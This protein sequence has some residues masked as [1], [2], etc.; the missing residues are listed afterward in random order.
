R[1]EGLPYFF[2]WQ[3]DEENFVEAA[4][5]EHLR[6]KGGDVVRSGGKKHAGF[7]VLHPGKK[8]GEKRLRETS[9]GGTAGTRRSEG[10]FD[11][12]DPENDGRHFLRKVESLAQFL[13]AFA[14]EFVVE[15]ASVEAS[16]FEAP[17]A[18]DGFCGEAL[19]A[20]LNA[21][22]QDSFGWLKPELAAFGGE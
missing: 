20:A 5:A 21:G 19:T 13:F 11:F 1:E 14:D 22:N 3:I 18:R 10:F 2:V 9:V 6:R 16:K 15:R 7:A 17:F 4:L 12:V 8:G